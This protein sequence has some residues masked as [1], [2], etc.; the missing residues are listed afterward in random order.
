MNVA[1]I[2]NVLR[3]NFETIKLLSNWPE[4][5]RV[6]PGQKMKTSCLRFRNGVV[7]HAQS[8]DTVQWLFR[9]VWVDQ[10][11]STLG[12]EIKRGDTV[13][14]VGSQHRRVLD[15]CGDACTRR[16]GFFVRALCKQRRLAPRKT[17]RTVA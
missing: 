15:V 6:R 9:E 16:D 1:N 7:L 17:L 10:V 12:Y 2:P 3:M 8:P 14:D 11:Y 4:V 5:I 13:I